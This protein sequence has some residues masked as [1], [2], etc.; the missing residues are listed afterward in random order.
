MT[1]SQ[2]ELYLKSFELKLGLDIQA[3]SCTI[4]T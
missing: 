2:S 4:C 1:L 3:I